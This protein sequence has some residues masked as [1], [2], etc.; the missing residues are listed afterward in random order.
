MKTPQYHP[1]KPDVLLSLGA[2][3]ELFIWDTSGF[4]CSILVR[5]VTERWLN[6]VR[7]SDNGSQV[8]IVESG[9]VLVLAVHW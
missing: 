8:A 7:M 1:V 3:K 2:S 4:T 9:H 5:W 6:D